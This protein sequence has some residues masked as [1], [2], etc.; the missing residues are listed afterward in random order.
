MATS[1]RISQVEEA[2]K[3]KRNQEMKIIRVVSQKTRSFNLAA[4]VI[5]TKAYVI[6]K[7]LATHLV[8]LISLS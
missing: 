4:Y 8:K 6:L 3:E 1:S 2:I 7:I 5:S